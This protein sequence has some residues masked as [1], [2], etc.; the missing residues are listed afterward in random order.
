MVGQELNIQTAHHDPSIISLSSSV[1]LMKVA[2]RLAK[3]RNSYHLVLRAPRQQKTR[4]GLPK[5]LDTL[6][7]HFSSEQVCSLHEGGDEERHVLMER[8]FRMCG[9]MKYCCLN[10]C[11]Y[12]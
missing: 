11:D 6:G 3:P 1:V 2:S 8:P 7:G 4:I 12:L 9:S 5:M 10:S